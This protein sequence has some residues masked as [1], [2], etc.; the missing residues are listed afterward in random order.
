MQGPPKNLK[1]L[2]ADEDVMTVMRTFTAGLGVR[3]DFC[4]MQGDMASDSNPKK[5]TARMMLSMTRE[6]NASHFNGRERI[7]CYTCHHGQQEPERAPAA[8][9]PPASPG[10]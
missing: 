3:C 10:R 9:A 2:K 4:H 1:V 6:L 7:S 5:V 8:G